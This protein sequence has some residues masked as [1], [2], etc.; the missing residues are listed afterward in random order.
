MDSTTLR[1]EPPSSPSL[2]YAVACGLPARM[3]YTI[4]QT[5][6]YTGLSEYQI[7]AAITSGELAAAMPTGNLRGARIPVR[8]VDAYMGYAT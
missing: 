7:K 4:G 6:R 1:P 2:G 5:A 3:S 8:A